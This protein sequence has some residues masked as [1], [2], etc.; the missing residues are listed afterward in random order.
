LRLERSRNEGTKDDCAYYF[1]IATIIQT[2]AGCERKS[3]HH[4]HV[5]LR[6]STSDLIKNEGYVFPWGSYAYVCPP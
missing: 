5:V 4:V 2:P 1:G 6:T 3:C